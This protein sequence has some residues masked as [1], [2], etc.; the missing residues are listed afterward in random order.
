MSATEGL[1]QLLTLITDPDQL[2]IVQIMQP[3][4]LEVQAAFVLQRNFAELH[5]TNRFVQIQTQLGR[6]WSDIQAEARKADSKVFPT[7]LLNNGQLSKAT[8]M[9]SALFEEWK[10]SGWDTVCQPAGG[11]GGVE[12][13]L[14]QT[15]GEAAAGAGITIDRIRAAIQ[16]GSFKRY[17][18]NLEQ[19]PVGK[20]EDQGYRIRTLSFFIVPVMANAILGA[21]ASEAFFPPLPVNGSGFAFSAVVGAVRMILDQFLVSHRNIEL[22]DIMMNPKDNQ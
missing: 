18:C 6:L 9:P 11:C 14:N 1:T 4:C 19:E 2:Y 5:K 16:S 21:E 8:K 13:A 22:D 17:T 15:A 20:C 12:A 10:V 7:L 3:T